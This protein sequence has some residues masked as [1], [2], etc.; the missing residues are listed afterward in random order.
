M[1]L[2][3]SAHVGTLIRRLQTLPTRLLG[4]ARTTTPGDAEPAGSASRRVTLAAGETVGADAD[5]PR[6][7]AALADAAS[8]AE[9]D[10]LLK[11]LAAGNSV[12]AVVAFAEKLR[13]RPEE[14]LRT[15]L[16]LLDPTT[17]GTVTY[18]GARFAQTDQTTCGTTTVMAARLLADPIYA[19]RLTTGDR[20]DDPT[21]TSPEAY[22]RRL[23]AEQKSLRGW[24]NR[25]WPEVL[26]TTPWGVRRGLS[27][28]AVRYTVHWADDTDD[29][30]IAAAG[31]A[32]ATGLDSGH[33][34]PLLVGDFYPAH[35]LLAVSRTD[36]RIRVYNPA[37]ARVVDTHLD[38]VR[39]GIGDATNFRHL[40]GYLIPR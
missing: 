31:A 12:P 38:D 33:P 22:E 3:D 27:H 8:D 39:R 4:T 35:Y 10:Y 2:P 13:G 32:I 17:P 14:W 26:G 18:R 40:H 16:T 21:S 9:R 37:N 28:L 24:T 11:A 15:H 25:L 29:R 7:D 19:F 36:Q 1:A 30:D 5:D 20:P 34:V 23:V 6:L